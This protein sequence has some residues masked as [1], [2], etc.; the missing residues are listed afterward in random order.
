MVSPQDTLDCVV[1][2]TDTEG[3]TVTSTQSVTIQNTSP[4]LDS[5]TLSPDPVYISDTLT[6]SVT[7]SDIDEDVSSQI[8]I[9]IQDGQGN[10]LSSAMG[11]PSLSLDLSG[12]GLSSGDTISCHGSVQDAYGGSDSSSALITLSNSAPVF[13][14]A[15]ISPPIQ[16]M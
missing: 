2:A 8:S 14:V 6:C 9:E 3:A 4:T 5:V 16:V 12:T 1:T 7:A 13:D 11:Q 10:V 15:A